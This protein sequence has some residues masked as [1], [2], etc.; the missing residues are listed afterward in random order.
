MAKFSSLLYT[1]FFMIYVSHVSHATI[2]VYNVI[3][4]GAIPD[5]ITDST[6]AFL[7]V[8]FAA[9]S[10]SSDS[11]N[12][13]NVPKGSYSL[14]S[15]V[16]QGKCKSSDITFQINGTLV[17]PPDYRVLGPYWLSFEG[18]SGVTIFGGAL[19]AKG[20]SLWACKAAGSDCPNGATVLY[21]YEMSIWFIMINT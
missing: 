5:G 11:S 14:G 13:I 12:I 16:F 2:N 10:A 17:P 3:N 9:C 18:V 6:P 4:F 7:R 15:L 8:W 1:L 19:D 20:K 21:L